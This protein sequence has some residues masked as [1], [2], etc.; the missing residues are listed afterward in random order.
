MYG[1]LAGDEV[2]RE[3]VRRL[4]SSV[5][6]Y[7]FVGRFGGGE[8]LVTLNNCDPAYGLVRANAICKTIQERPVET[9]AGS[10]AEPGMGLPAGG[11][12]SSRSGHRSL[13]GEGRRSQLRQS[14][15]SK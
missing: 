12:A 1:H 14:G 5:R 2:L 7:D 15:D 13:R 6:S 11:G 10:S 4:V 8:F 9:S 3:T